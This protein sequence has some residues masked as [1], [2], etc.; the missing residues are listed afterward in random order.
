[1]G[2]KDELDSRLEMM[3]QTPDSGAFWEET[4]GTP[5]QA[6]LA[7]FVAAVC[8]HRLT[9]APPSWLSMLV[10]RDHIARHRR[11]FSNQIGLSSAEIGE[12]AALVG[13]RQVSKRPRREARW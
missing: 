2:Q 5:I 7:R 13:E 3:E 11:S 4:R 12:R 9:R 6:E 1:M 8:E 10:F